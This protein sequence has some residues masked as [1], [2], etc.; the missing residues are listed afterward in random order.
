M[1]VNGFKNISAYFKKNLL[2]LQK[3]IEVQAAK[4]EEL[5]ILG[6][7]YTSWILNRNNFFVLSCM[8]IQSE[9]P[10]LLRE[11]SNLISTQFNKVIINGNIIF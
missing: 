10:A 9:W 11:K 1:K 3:C 4:I 2:P 6:V 8:T 5:L 7:D